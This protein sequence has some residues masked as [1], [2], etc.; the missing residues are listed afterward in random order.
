MFTTR[1]RTPSATQAL[2]RLERELHLA[3]AGDEDASSGVPPR[4][5]SAST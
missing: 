3:A 5:A 2:V 1:E 4:A